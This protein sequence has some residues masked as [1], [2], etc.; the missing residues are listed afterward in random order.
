MSYCSRSVPS[1]EV[2]GITCREGP[3][4]ARR[5]LRPKRLPIRGA[6]KEKMNEW[7]KTKGSLPSDSPSRKL[8]GHVRVHPAHSCAGQLQCQEHDDSYEHEDQSILRQRLSAF[9]VQSV[10]RIEEKLSQGTNQ[11]IH[12]YAP[13]FMFSRSLIRIR[14]DQEP[15]CVRSDCHVRIFHRVWRLL[16]TFSRKNGEKRPSGSLPEPDGFNHD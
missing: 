11:N 8:R 6:T 1:F 7:I 16:Q 4:Y 12:D 3:S 13:P 5:Q 10:F 9:V 2:I 14:R 15:F